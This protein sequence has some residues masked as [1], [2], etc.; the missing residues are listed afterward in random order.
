MFLKVLIEIVDDTRGLRVYSLLFAHVFQQVFP[1]LLIL[2]EFFLDEALLFGD[3]LGY[4]FMILRILFNQLNKRFSKRPISRNLSLKADV[5]DLVHKIRDAK[6]LLDFI[7]ALLE[8]VLLV[9][10]DFFDIC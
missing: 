3:D 10:E 9:T 2:E 4:L 6:H 5:G 7:L 8:E 1:D